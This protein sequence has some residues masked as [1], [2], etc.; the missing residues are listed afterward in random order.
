[1][2]NSMLNLMKKLKK[3]RCDPIDAC[4]IEDSKVVEW[5]NPHKPSNVRRSDS[6]EKD[7]DEVFSGEVTT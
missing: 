2:S 7:D 5:L 4:N 1:M 6:D 3:R